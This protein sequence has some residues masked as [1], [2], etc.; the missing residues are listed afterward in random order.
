MNPGMQIRRRGRK[1][2]S[3]LLAFLGL[4]A[5]ALTA[6][7][8][9]I[10]AP[11][12]AQGA[13]GFLEAP[14]GLVPGGA[15][16]VPGLE[17]D[18]IITGGTVVDGSGIVGYVADVGIKDGFIYSI[19]DLSSA[20][21]RRRIDARGLIVA[22]GFIDTHSHA[23][24]ALLPGALS[25]LSQGVTTEIL[26][27]DG[28]GPTNIGAQLSRL[29]AGGLGINVGAFIGF[30]AAW[31]EVAGSANR[32][33]SSAD[34][35]RMRAIIARGMADG[36]FGVSSGLFYAP[37][38]F[39]TTEEVR[40]VSEAARPWRAVYSTHVRDESF[41]LLA[42]ITE[43]IDI[44]V[45]AGLTPD[46][47]HMKVGSPYTWGKAA[48]AVGI[49]KQANARGVYTTASVYPYTASS[50]SLTAIVPP[51]VQEGGRTAML[52]RFRDPALREQIA[53]EIEDYMRIWVRT[54]DQVYFPDQRRT[55]A[56]EAAGMG[57]VSA[58]EAVIRILEAG[59]R[60]TIYHF[61]SE[62]DLVT[63]L[64]NPY[65]A[66]ASDGGVTTATTVHPRR[67]GTFP[68]VLGRYVREQGILSWQEAIRKMT[69]LPATLLGLVDRGF[70]A[71]GMAADI[72][73]FDPKTIIDRATFD[74]PNQYSEGVHY[75]LVNG[76]VAFER[77][78]LTG[79]RAGIALRKHPNAPS[80]PMNP[81]HLV[82]ASGT[83]ALL[84]QGPGQWSDISFDFAARQLPDEAR[85][86]G[87]VRIRDWVR[88]LELVAVE[89][90]KL[91]VAGGWASLTGLGLV[92]GREARVFRII[93][94]Q[95][96]PF[97]NGQ[98]SVSVWIHG[99]LDVRGGLASGSRVQV[100]DRP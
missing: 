86:T 90:G 46:I 27:P 51:W 3:L 84:L 8:S 11:A 26:N 43:A 74:N 55:L 48:E 40:A 44:A 69:G 67:Y 75:V 58:G 39:A 72:T 36:A 68:R 32:R 81:P 54:P 10:G 38:V 97:L 31:S 33:L 13:T 37:A 92:N 79:T 87:F 85:A 45:G 9:G 30:N 52:A 17:F 82:Q 50:T 76:Q 78:S 99:L 65:A 62:A 70:I 77:G 73:V 63:L 83:G 1:A 57:G 60:R 91:Q 59:N 88:D 34:I 42:A 24:E 21:A 49:I 80:R 23:E 25:S 35:E 16:A 5:A 56:D 14:K 95:R 41:G 7:V 53:R 12:L 2:A 94:D 18:I 29:E 61:G 96:D 100:V 6:A 64:A 22:P 15:A 89:L 98:P 66:I 71:A 47:T 20:P 4:W 28:E 93:V 19:G